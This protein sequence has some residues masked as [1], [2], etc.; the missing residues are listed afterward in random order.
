MEGGKRASE[1]GPSSGGSSSACGVGEERR[2]KHKEMSEKPS[3]VCFVGEEEE[4]DDDAKGHG[5][6]AGFVPGPLVSLKEQIE[7]DK[8]F[9]LFFF[10]H[11]Q[12]LSILNYLTLGVALVYCL[13]NLMRWVTFEDFVQPGNAMFGCS[14]SSKRKV[15]KFSSLGFFVA[16]TRA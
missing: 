10:S 2:E 9:V 1:A 16:K 13:L 12:F 3:E 8:V 5:V 7:K 6:V 14:K 4:D 15:I 11:L